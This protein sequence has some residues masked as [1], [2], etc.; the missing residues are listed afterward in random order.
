MSEPYDPLA[1]ENQRLLPEEITALQQAAV[2]PVPRYGKQ[3]KIKFMQFPV[4]HYEALAQQK[5]P[6]TAFAVLGIAYQNWYAPPHD[7]VIASIRY[8]ERSKN[9]C[10]FN[11]GENWLHSSVSRK[12]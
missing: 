5:A 10:A 11:F 6:W 9:P 3:S 12:T 1:L 8:F 7:P 2:R 4:P